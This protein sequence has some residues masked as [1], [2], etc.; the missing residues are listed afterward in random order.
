MDTDFPLPGQ[1]RGY[2][3]PAGREDEE[4]REWTRAVE[5]DHQHEAS[6]QGSERDQSGGD[7]LALFEALQSESRPGE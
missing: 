1:N 3:N 2:G 4:R 6:G 7:A 5:S